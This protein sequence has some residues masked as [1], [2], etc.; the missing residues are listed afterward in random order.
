M[1][2]NEEISRLDARIQEGESKLAE[3]R[4]A[5]GEAWKSLADSVDLAWA[6]LK[7]GFSDAAAKFDL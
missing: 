6:S 3:I 5:S 2:L 7:Q 4:A 1:K